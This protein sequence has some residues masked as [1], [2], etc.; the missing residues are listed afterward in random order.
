MP[1]TA[2]MTET[3]GPTDPN[4]TFA[5]STGSGESG[6]YDGPPVQRFRPGGPKEARL[7]RVRLMET[8]RYYEAAIARGEKPEDPDAFYSL[9]VSNLPL[10]TT[11]LQLRDEFTVFGKVGDV[12]RPIDKDTK[13]PC[14]F[15]FIRFVYRKD[16]LA[17]MDAL[18]GKVINGRGMKIMEA[19]PGRYELDT[20]IY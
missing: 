10:M 20:S 3:S 9:K 16:M 18:Q 13:K 5:S 8:G 12:Y 4:S 17:A 6:D 11:E 15:V 7:N 2:Q 19:K 1:H 14:K